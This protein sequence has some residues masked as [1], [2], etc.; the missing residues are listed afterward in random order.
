MSLLVPKERP[1]LPESYK[2]PE[3]FDEVIIVLDLVV[4]NHF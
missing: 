3:V 1:T 4:F 2:L